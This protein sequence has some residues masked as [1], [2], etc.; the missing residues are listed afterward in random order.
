M[1][2]VTPE[3]IAAVMALLPLPHSFAELDDR[4]AHGLPK[5]ALKA[6]VDRVLLAGEDRK[7]LL[8]RIVPEATYKRR[9]GTLTADE[10]GRA[11]RLARVFATADYVWNSEDD[12]RAFLSAPHPMLQGRTPLDVSMTELGARRVEELL[13]KLYYGLAA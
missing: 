3:K 7:K 1:V 10:S 9:R 13:W 2:L 6:S 11:E 8:Y 4:I 5:D 12:A